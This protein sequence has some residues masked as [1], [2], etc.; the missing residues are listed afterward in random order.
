[1]RLA[2]SPPMLHANS[3]VARSLDFLGSEFIILR[4]DQTLLQSGLVK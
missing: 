2:L 3:N 4:H 1:M